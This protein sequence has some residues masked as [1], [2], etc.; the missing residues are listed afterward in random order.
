MI[1]D[2]GGEMLVIGKRPDVSSGAEVGICSVVGHVRFGSE[3]HVCFIPNS[4]RESGLPQAVMSALPLKA[5]M[6]SAK[7]HVCVGPIADI[8]TYQPRH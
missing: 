4:D 5:D 6:C 3:R 1:R 7:A 8:S 2:D